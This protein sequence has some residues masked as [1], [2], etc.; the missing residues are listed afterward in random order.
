MFHSTSYIMRMLSVYR[1]NASHCGQLPNGSQSISDS[2]R[3]PR[4]KRDV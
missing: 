4:C 2:V 1:S 3:K